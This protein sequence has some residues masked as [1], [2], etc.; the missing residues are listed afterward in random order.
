MGIV[1]NRILNLPTR[2]FGVS[3]AGTLG[4][5]KLVV[6]LLNYALSCTGQTV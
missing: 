5:I 1:Q 2:G 4:F 3:V 6:Q